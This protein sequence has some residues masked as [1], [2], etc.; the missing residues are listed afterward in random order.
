VPYGTVPSRTGRYAPP[1]GSMIRDN[2]PRA[3]PVM[4]VQPQSRRV[5]NAR[6]PRRSHVTASDHDFMDVRG[7]QFTARSCKALP[8]ASPISPCM[9]A[10]GSRRLPVMARPDCGIRKRAKCLECSVAMKTGCAQWPFHL[11]ANG[12]RRL[13]TMVL[14]DCGMWMKAPQMEFGIVRSGISRWPE[15]IQRALSKVLSHFKARV[16]YQRA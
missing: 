11:T 12:S 6:K 15:R 7:D 4:P 2:S 1:R 5:E 14:Q 8:L 10:N 9:F 3:L 16:C 13:L